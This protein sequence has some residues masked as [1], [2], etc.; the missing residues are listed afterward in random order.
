MALSTRHLR[1]VNAV[2]QE[3]T[4]TA[5]ARR[6]FVTQSALSHQLAELERRVGTAV[7]HRVGKRLVPTAVG[8]RILEVAA[9]LL[10]SL[11]D[12]EED[13]ARVASGRSGTLRLTTECHT[14]YHWLPEIFPEFRK[15]H[16]D[17]EL[18]IVPEASSR[19]VDAVLRGEVDLSLAYAFTET[20]LVDCVTLFEDEM[21]LIVGTEHRL[22]ERDVV[23]GQD[24]RGEHL[25]FYVHRPESSL[26]YQKVL[27]PE[28]IVPGRI[29]E[30][31]LTEGIV[32]L[33]AAG[34][35]VA[36][37]TRWSVAP[38]IAAGTIKA[39][40]ITD[41]GLRRRWNAAFLRTSERP[42]YLDTFVR[43]LAGGP[44]RLYAS[45]RTRATRAAA[46]ITVA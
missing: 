5:A 3:G 22:A 13:L 16:P 30:V 11:R 33:V 29:S 8:R 41:I 21:V 20:P 6:L 4:L 25:L 10:G 9:P 12:L 43:L 28:G 26:L 19:P 23:H 38:Q 40:R 37:V 32:A 2:A 42:A 24:L 7:F 46:G 18:Q 17:I 27:T 15:L 45:A 39:L 14:G 36:A 35:G 31:P 1:L 34:V 44:A